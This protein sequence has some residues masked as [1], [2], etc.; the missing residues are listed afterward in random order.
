VTRCAN[1]F[2]PY[3][4][5]TSSADVRAL[6]SQRCQA[7]MV[8]ELRRLPLRVPAIPTELPPRV[9]VQQACRVAGVCRR[10]IYN[11]IAAGR[12]DYVRTAGG[13]IRIL[14]PTLMRNAA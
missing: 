9:T 6:C 7:E 1:C 4:P 14:T 8:R 12:V 11:W 13:A 10:T 5:A 3:D 2:E